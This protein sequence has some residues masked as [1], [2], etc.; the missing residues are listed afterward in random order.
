MCGR[1]RLAIERGRGDGCPFCSDSS[2]KVCKHSNLETDHPAIAA[3][4]DPVRNGK[5]LPSEFR[6]GSHS[7]VYWRCANDPCGCHMWRASINSRTG[8][9]Y[10]CPFCS[11][12]GSN[13]VCKHSNLETEHP[14][15]AAEWGYD[16][17]KNLL[18]SE[19][20]P[21]SNLSV[22]WRCAN[23][24]CGCHM[25]KASINNRT[26]RGC[27]CPFCS[28]GGSNKVCK[29]SNLETEHPDIAAEWGYDL[30]KNLLPSEFRPSSNLSVWWRCATKREHVWKT[31][32]CHRTRNL[33]TGCPHCAK[34]RGYSNAQIVWLK[35]IEEEQNIDI[36]H[37]LSPSG[38]H[39]IPTVGKVDGFHALSNTV[40]EYHGDFWHGNPNIYD[41]DE[42]NPVSKKSFGYLYQK[43][44]KREAR[45]RELGYSLIVKWES[46]TPHALE[47]GCYSDSSTNLDAMSDSSTD[48]G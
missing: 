5:L 38:E 10:G 11:N 1:R 44:L 32:I 37:A 31:A 41:T 29:H 47:Y 42:I 45:I 3:E 46:E 24:P 22:W 12:G 18:P 9:G 2:D 34:S 28:N 43:T 33:P 23:D 7:V 8:R 17:N 40:Y 36:T 14:D 21:S 26:G 16:L 15:I 39:Y 35:S 48:L 25:W 30:N 27:G 19:F 13:K 20:R 6:P 4:W